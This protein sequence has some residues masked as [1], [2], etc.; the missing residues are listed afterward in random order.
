MTKH[1]DLE[2]QF[3]IVKI[4][5]TQKHITI[6]DL[7]TEYQRN[8]STISRILKLHKIPI[9]ITKFSKSQNKSIIQQYVSGLSAT[10]ISKKYDCGVATITSILKKYNVTRRTLSEACLKYPFN[11]YFFDVID[12]DSK[13]YFLGLLF[14]DGYNN[15]EEGRVALGLKDKCSVEQFAAA[16]ET[17]HP[18]ITK[19]YPKW[20][21]HTLNIH[22]RYFSQQLAK[23]G[24]VQ[25]KSHILTFPTTVPDHLMHHFVR[26]YF[27]GD[28]CIHV[29]KNSDHRVV[30]IIGT[31]AFL[32]GM[33]KILPVKS[34][35]K[36]RSKKTVFYLG[37]YKKNDVSVFAE[38]L[39]KDT[40]IFMERKRTMF[41][42]S[43]YTDEEI[44]LKKANEA[45]K[46]AEYRKRKKV[47]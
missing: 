33:G 18:V 31:E 30:H 6:T 14:A 15:E 45:V 16:I 24:C 1:F 8:I 3:D 40:T 20:T 29:R 44:K 13:A 19:E 23:H 27:D 32:N 25:A 28:G 36:Q 17:N 4:Y 9:R 34:S 35:I 38:W 11:Q 12:T 37:I 10:K 39:Y 42:E 46:T 26:G 41:F 2:T 5:K 21:T 43:L 7:A 22:G 47:E